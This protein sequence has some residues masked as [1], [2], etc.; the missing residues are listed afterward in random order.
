MKMN[1]NLTITHAVG[2]TTRDF[3]ADDDRFDLFQVSDGF[4]T[5]DIHFHYA[6][7]SDSSDSVYADNSDA[8]LLRHISG[9]MHLIACVTY[10]IMKGFQEDHSFHCEQFYDEDGNSVTKELFLLPL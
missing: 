4:K 7:D 5:V 10:T 1:S 3:I 9:S 8:C 6:S 2:N